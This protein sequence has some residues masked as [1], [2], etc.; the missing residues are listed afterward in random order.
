M[1]RVFWLR[2]VSHFKTKDRIQVLFWFVFFY[3]L[4]RN[5]GNKSF[6]IFCFST[7]KPKLNGHTVHGPIAF[8]SLSLFYSVAP[9][10]FTL[11]LTVFN[12][13]YLGH[14][15]MFGFWTNSDLGNRLR[16]IWLH[17]VCVLSIRIRVSPGP[18]LKLS[19]H[20]FVKKFLSF[21]AG[22]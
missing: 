10:Q 15:Q 1:S 14:Q 17:H 21:P 19:S 12:M 13:L 7:S 11:S 5:V 4:K 16:R 3:N 6:S 2:W 8:L 22:V 9:N 18:W 20:V